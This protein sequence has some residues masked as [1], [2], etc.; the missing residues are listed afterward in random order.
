M[1][2]LVVRRGYRERG[3]A[4]GILRR[5]G[6]GVEVEREG[7]GKGKGVDVWGVAS[8]NPA[9]VLAVGGLLVGSLLFSPFLPFFPSFIVSVP[10]SPSSPPPQSPP[11][12]SPPPHNLSPPLSSLHLPLPHH[13]FAPKPRTKLKPTKPPP[14]P[15]TAPGKDIDLAFIRQHAEPI[16]RSSPIPYLRNAK[17][18]GRIFA[19]E[20]G[21]ETGDGEGDEHGSGMG[22]GVVDGDGDGDA[23][24]SGDMAFCVD[25]AEPREVLRR[26]EGAGRGWVLG[27]GGVGG[28]GVVLIEGGR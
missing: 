26:V 16:L 13:P 19:R 9:A 6:E 11:P 10:S 21:S 15:G 20:L 4:T 5:L 3:V 18:R 27:E 28:V 24:G 1:T 8:C 22:D 12:I 23:E 17:L 14:P 7:E 2:Q 25:H